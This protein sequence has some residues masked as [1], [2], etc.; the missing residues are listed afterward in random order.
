MPMIINI[1]IGRAA[2]ILNVFQCCRSRR[3]IVE[4]VYSE[5]NIKQCQKSTM[6]SLTL[7]NI[8]KIPFA[9][10]K[11][12]IIDSELLFEPES[13][14]QN[15]IFFYNYL[16]KM[17]VKLQQRRLVS[18]D[19]SKNILICALCISEAFPILGKI[20]TEFSHLLKSLSSFD[21]FQK[22]I[23]LLRKIL[24]AKF[25]YKD[26]SLNQIPPQ[27]NLPV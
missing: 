1:G 10:I 15:T 18:S 24:E 9:S 13:P 20:L 26:A 21:T 14:A 25:P 8:V 2:Q 3:K 23:I 17:I 7:S 19:S 5:L 22:I 6:N 12:T 4:T 27:W 11:Y 16:T